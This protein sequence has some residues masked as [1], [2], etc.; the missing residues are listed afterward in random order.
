V[1]TG[2]LFF[3]GGDAESPP[4]PIRELNTVF[5]RSAR[6]P[7]V[8]VRQLAKADGRG[9]LEQ[10]LDTPEQI[11][12]AFSAQL[13]APLYDD[14]RLIVGTAERGIYAVPTTAEAICLGLFPNGGG[15]CGLPG[16]HGVLLRSPLELDLGT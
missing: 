14:R 15:S 10:E 9:G 13:G 1:S 4:A 16:P 5:R 12:S 7:D 8:F 6:P 2:S 11:R 3:L